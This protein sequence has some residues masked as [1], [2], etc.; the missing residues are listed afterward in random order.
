MLKTDAK[1]VI[2]EKVT[3]NFY[4]YYCRQKFS[5]YNFFWVIFLNFFQRIRT[6]HQM[7]RLMIIPILNFCKKN[8]LPILALFANFLKSVAKETA[9]KKRKKRVL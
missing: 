7:L 4:F 2:S 1:K 8:V 9:A 3:E 5:A 6:Q